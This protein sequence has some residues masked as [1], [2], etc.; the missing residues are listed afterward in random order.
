MLA[1]QQQPTLFTIVVNSGGEV[2]D[3]PLQSFS[4][5]GIVVA[6]EA[7]N[8]TFKIKYS[9]HTLSYNKLPK[10]STLSDATKDTDL[11]R[12]RLIH[13]HTFGVTDTFIN[14]LHTH[15]GC[16]VKEIFSR[17]NY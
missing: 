15:K 16:V 2:Y 12:V 6:Y 7:P 13:L 4:E 11:L 9:A 8:S 10:S 3:D 17:H 1:K 5:T 14:K